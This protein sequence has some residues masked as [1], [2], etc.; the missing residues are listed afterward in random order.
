[1]ITEVLTWKPVAEPPD[2]DTTVLGSTRPRQSRSGRAIW[3]VR[4][5]AMPMAR[6]LHLR[7]GARC[8]EGPRHEPTRPC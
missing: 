6:K 5:G 4:R 8:R 2:S 7:T 1:M 3:M